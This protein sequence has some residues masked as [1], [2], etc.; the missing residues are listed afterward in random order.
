[1]VISLLLMK[2]KII[3]RLAKI[4]KSYAFTLIIGIL[5]IITGVSELLETIIPDFEAYLK[6]HHGL[7]ILGIVH[8]GKSLV[9][10]LEGAEAI[11]IN[12]TAEEIKE[13]DK[14]LQ[15]LKQN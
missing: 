5:L 13:I 7:I 4:F 12:E 8:I 10:I 9:Y 14:D 6:T 3:N 1:M 2:S 11:L 15:H